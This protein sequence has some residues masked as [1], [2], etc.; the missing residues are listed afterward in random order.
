[1]GN[2]P[3]GQVDLEKGLNSKSNRELSGSNFITF[4]LSAYALGIITLF[5]CFVIKGRVAYLGLLKD[6]FIL[7]N[8]CNR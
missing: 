2:S 8:R 7:Q 5:G 4:L 3:V 1:M 6:N